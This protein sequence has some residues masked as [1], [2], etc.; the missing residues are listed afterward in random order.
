[1]FSA[2]TLIRAFHPSC[3]FKAFT[4]HLTEG[5]HAVFRDRD[6]EHKLHACSQNPRI[7]HQIAV[8]PEHSC[9]GLIDDLTQGRQDACPTITHVCVNP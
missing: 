6:R 7:S 1:V 8:P 4:Q 5:E 2:T 3:G 9:S